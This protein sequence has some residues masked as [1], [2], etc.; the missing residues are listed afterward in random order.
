[1]AGQLSASLSSMDAHLMYFK[2]VSRS[3]PFVMF[4][5]SFL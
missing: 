2:K 5:Y 3:L 1:V 4:D